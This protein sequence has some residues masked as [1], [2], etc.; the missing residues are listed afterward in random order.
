[1]N[2]AFAGALN[3][4]DVELL[5]ALYEPDA[6]LV[7]FPGERAVGKAAIREALA[8]LLALNGRMTSQNNYCLRVGELAL[9]QGQWRLTCTGEDGQTVEQTARSAE[10]VRQ[11]ADGSWLYVI[12]HPFGD[13]EAR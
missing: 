11:Q 12:D 9:L 8:G 1:M 4:G 7:P 6:V 13:D 10:I 5:L 2:A 3:S